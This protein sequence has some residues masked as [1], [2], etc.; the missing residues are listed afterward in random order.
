M[1]FPT[2]AKLKSRSDAAQPRIIFASGSPR[3][4]GNPRHYKYVW[5]VFSPESPFEGDAFLERAPRLC[6]AAFE[7]ETDR[8]LD[9][10]MTC[11][12][13][14]F[15]LPRRDPASPWDLAHPRWQDREFAPSW[16]EDTDPIVSGDHK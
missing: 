4:M 9:Q 5:Q 6:N 13:Y 12:V 1:L 11:L 8:L 14:G 3:P 7:K 2:H 15:R 16:E 10:G